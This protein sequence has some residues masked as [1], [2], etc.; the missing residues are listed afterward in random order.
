MF[1]LAKLFARSFF[2]LMHF[3]DSLMIAYVY[4][5]S[6]RR[7]VKEDVPT[8]YEIDCLSFKISRC[9]L[10]LGR[11]L[12]FTPAQMEGFDYDNGR[13]VEKAYSMLLAWKQREG[14]QAT[15]RVLSEALCDIGRRD[16]GQEFNK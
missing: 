14:S 15:Y 13:V 11:R 4:L 3:L 7:S 9:W 5:E 8:D 1:I 16:L 12:E 6:K 10:R 2:Q